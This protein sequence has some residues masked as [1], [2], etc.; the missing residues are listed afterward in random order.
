MFGRI[1]EGEEVRSGV[2]HGNSCLFPK[3]S[4]VRVG[5][6]IPRLLDSS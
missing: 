4:S 2:K 6:Y 3:A 1:P 5:Q